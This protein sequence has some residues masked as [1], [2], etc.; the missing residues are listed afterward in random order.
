MQVKF[1]MMHAFLVSG[2]NHMHWLDWTCWQTHTFDLSAKTLDSGWTTASKHVPFKQSQNTQQTGNVYLLC[3]FTVL[4]YSG[5]VAWVTSWVLHSVL[6]YICAYLSNY[7]KL[8]SNLG[9]Y[10]VPYDCGINMTTASLYLCKIYCQK[11][12]Y[13]IPRHKAREYTFVKIL[14]C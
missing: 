12:P 5:N 10:Y 3:L 13:S 11:H 8:A 6:K 4:R 1:E 14:E 9:F 2:V 7:M